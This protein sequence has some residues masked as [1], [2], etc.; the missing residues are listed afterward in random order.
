MIRRSHRFRIGV[1]AFLAALVVIGVSFMVVGEVV[2]RMNLQAGHD[3]L[4]PLAEDVSAEFHRDRSVVDLSRRVPDDI[5]VGVFEGGNTI[6]AAGAAPL[7]A[8]SAALVT[9][10]DGRAWVTAAHRKDGVTVVVA[11]DWS[12]EEK[13]QQTMALVLFLTW[14]PL[15]GFVGLA[16]Y[17]AAADMFRSLESL[18]RQA[19]ALSVAARQSRLSNEG[20]AEVLALSQEL[21]GMIDRIW[22]EV[23]RRDRMVADIAH[24]LRTPLTIIRGRLETLLLKNELDERSVRSVR[25]A[26]DETERLNEMLELILESGETKDA[27]PEPIDL[28]PIV[29]ATADR[30]TDQ[31]PN[32]RVTAESVEVAITGAEI[33]RLIENLLQNAHRFAPAQSAVDLELNR[34]GDYAVLS[35]GD[36]GPGISPEDRARIFDRFV[37]LE[38]SRNR[39]TGGFGLGL[40]VCREIVESRGGE[41]MITESEL[42]GA[43]FTVRLPAAG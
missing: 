27:S 5:S 28:E 6:L 33:T 30:W 42:G 12:G 21:N 17:R 38:E 20:D 19:G 37:R 36:A 29:R 31:L 7:E 13:A 26:V 8:A 35:V 32:L 10:S 41:I 24:D 3:A 43:K 16:A 34:D 15:A 23:G 11:R 40:A 25:I 18:T 9:S 2:H 39:G 14:I 1:A 22:A 4:R